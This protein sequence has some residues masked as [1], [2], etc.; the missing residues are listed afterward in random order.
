MTNKKLPIDYVTKDYDGFL[1]MTK[2]MIPSLTPE[3]TDNSDSDMGTVI[4]QLL[5][6]GLHVLGYYR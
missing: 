3:W 6:Y 1:Q 2:D 4:L 5:A